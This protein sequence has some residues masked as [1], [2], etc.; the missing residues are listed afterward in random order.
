MFS[1]VN[2]QVI[3]LV[4]EMWPDYSVNDY[5]YRNRLLNDICFYESVSPC[6]RRTGNI[7]LRTA[8]INMSSNR[9]YGPKPALE[10]IHGRMHEVR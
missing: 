2:H 3:L 8:R 7:F 4:A 6:H 1:M 5:L 9:K 10:A